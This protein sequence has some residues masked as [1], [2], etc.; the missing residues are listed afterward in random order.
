MDNV[1]FPISEAKA[2]ITAFENGT[3]PSAEWTHEAHLLVALY[4]V[5]LYGDAAF[6]EMKK[7]LLDYNPTVGRAGTFHAT[8]TWF[9]LEI[10]KKYMQNEAK[11]VLFNQNTVDDLLFE[12]D[13]A[14]RNLW[15]KYYS[16]ALMMSERARKEI[17]QVAL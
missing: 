9:W 1:L 10:V 8:M 13:L 17:I 11:Q 15:K 12:E 2:L 3:L 4:L 7:R 14:E 16:E 6:S 5:S